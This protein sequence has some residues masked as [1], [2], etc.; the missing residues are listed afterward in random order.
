MYAESDYSVDADKIHIGINTR[1]VA[2]LHKNLS[3]YRYWCQATIVT[4]PLLLFSIF[5]FALL[6]TM[7]FVNQIASVPL[8]F[9]MF[10]C[11]YL[12]VIDYSFKTKMISI[13]HKTAFDLHLKIGFNPF[14]LQKYETRYIKAKSQCE[15]VIVSNPF[16]GFEW[17]STGEHRKFLSD[18]VFYHGKYEKIPVRNKEINLPVGK[19]TLPSTIKCKIKFFFDEVPKNG[20]IRLDVY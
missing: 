12:T 10:Y 6:S 18:V 19:I 20:L 8:I 2:F 7:G 13:W 9:W 3:F 17:K 11:I 1:K 5:L 15:E 14:T 16:T 4:W